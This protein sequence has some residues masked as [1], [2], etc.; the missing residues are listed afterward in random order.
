[1]ATILASNDDSVEGSSSTNRVPHWKAEMKQAVRSGRELCELVGVAREI[2]NLSAEADFPVFVPPSYVRKIEF[3]NSADPLLKQVIGVSEETQGFG[4]IDAV[5]DLPAQRA[6]GV[7]QKYAGRA[8]LIASG[9]C[10]VN[11]RYCFRRH[12]PYDDAPKGK[13]LA[14][15]IDQLTEDPAIEEVIFSGGDPLTLSDSTLADLVA[16]CD[17]STGLRRLRFHTRLPV[18]IPQRINDE[19]L[20]WVGRLRLPI[21][22][23][24]HFN[25]VNEICDLAIQR[26]HALHRAGANLLNQTVLLKGVNDNPDALCELSNRMLDARVMPYYLH[27]L[28]PV[29]GAMHFEVPVQK[30]RA[31]VDAMRK[32]LPGYA[33]PRYVCETAGEQSKTPL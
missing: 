30:G 32:R 25:H 11:C 14:A 13:Q 3:G 27:Q 24:M 29:R 16:R 2:S 33:V 17:S 1:M 26:L 9:T 15:A 23:V 21:T 7:L 8:L 10:A 4:Q 31:I 28:D 20:G 5:G 19:L 12:F 6:P 18:V 22:F